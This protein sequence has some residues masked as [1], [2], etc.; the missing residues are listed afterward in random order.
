MG[1]TPHVTPTSE[2]PIDLVV[3]M[4]RQASMTDLRRRSRPTKHLLSM[5]IPRGLSMLRSTG[6][7]GHPV[8]LL[9]PPLGGVLGSVSR[10]HRAHRSLAVT[11]LRD[12]R[13]K[14]VSDC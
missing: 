14:A 2:L 11:S 5:K 12:G 7:A 4:G 8:P 3:D 10:Q 9:E 13:M 6:I 1:S